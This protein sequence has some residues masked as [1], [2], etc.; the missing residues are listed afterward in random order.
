MQWSAIDNYWGQP[1]FLG[2]MNIDGSTK[3]TDLS[4]T[5]LDVYDKLGLYNPKIQIKVNSS[6][7]R[8]FILKA[9]EMIRHGITSIVFCNDDIIT[10]C[11]MADGA[12]YE[13]AVDSLISGCY[14]YK[15]KEKTIGISVSYINVLKPISLVFDNGF[16][17][18]TGNKL[19]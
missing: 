18:V 9:L 12:T 7:P 11:L 13:E 1:F 3:V 15:A 17:T 2:G 16:D 14:E 19:V 4:Y 8:D 10:K 5:I 6:T